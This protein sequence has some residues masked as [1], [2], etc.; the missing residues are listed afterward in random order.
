MV[1]S[2]WEKQRRRLTELVETR[3]NE[4]ETNLANAS[5]NSSSA[6]DRRLEAQADLTMWNAE[7]LQSQRSVSELSDLLDFLKNPGLLVGDGYVGRHRKEDDDVLVEEDYFDYD[8][9]DDY[10]TDEG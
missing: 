8:A 3:L 5:S 1:E 2:N 6:E 7:V 9:Y 10:L 4:A